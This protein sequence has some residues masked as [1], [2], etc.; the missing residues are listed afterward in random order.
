MGI[1]AT[2]APGNGVSRVEFYAGTGLLASD[3]SAPYEFNWTGVAAGRYTVSARTV[4]TNG[5]RATSVLA[6]ITV[7]PGDSIRGRVVDRNGAPVSGLTVTLSGSQAAN[8]LTDSSGDYRFSNLSAGGNYT[9][10]PTNTAFD[11]FTPRSVTGLS[12]QATLDFN[13]TLRTYTISGRVVSANGSA[14]LTETLLTLTGTSGFPTQTTLS[15]ADGTYSFTNVPA[16]GNYTIN[17]TKNSE[18][19]GISA[20]DASLAARHAASLI[21][22]NTDQQIAA[23]ASNNS[24]VSASDATLIANSAIDVPNES[25]VGTWK[26]A[27]PTHA[28]SNLGAD[29]SGQDFTAV[30]V[31]DVSGSWTGLAHAAPASGS[32]TTPISVVLPDRGGSPGG[33]ARSR[34][35]SA[36]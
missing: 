30:L 20:F 14:S 7:N 34:S 18:P 29:L 24:V 4:A 2:P 5:A 23:D 1:S 36:T 26:F 32:S 19:A 12:G 6:D 35:M 10:T 22:L 9:V 16:A 8:T 27:Q 33:V 11:S 17:A 31:G 21:A 25:I 28:I 15:L 3:N 13:G